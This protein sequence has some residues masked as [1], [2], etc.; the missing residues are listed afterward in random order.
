MEITNKFGAPE[1]LVT[2]ASKDYYEKGASHYSVTELLSPPR[3]RRLRQKH[4]ADIEVDVSDSLWQMLGSALHVIAERSTTKNWTNEERVFVEIN[5]CLISGQIDAQQFTDAGVILWDYKFTSAYSVMNEK[6][7][8]E[9]QLNLYAQLVRMVKGQT[10]AGLRICALIRDWSRHKATDENYPRSQIHVIEIALWD[11]ETAEK[12]LKERLELHRDV[13]MDFELHGQLP[14]CTPQEQWRTETTYA[15][16]R[17]GRKTAIKVFDNRAEADERA[18]KEKGYVEVR[19]GEPRRCT[20]NFC[21][22]AHWCE[23]Y[24]AYVAETER[25]RA[26]GEEAKPDLP[27]MG[28]GMGSGSEG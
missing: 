7:E 17:E 26:H 12:F 20:G 15:V 14:P 8:W 13:H 11:E 27:V 25:E 19:E 3:I 18:I 1:P 21:G 2:L 6:P 24:R 16:K 9:E 23:Q 4:H 10:I 28:V 5:D 22:V